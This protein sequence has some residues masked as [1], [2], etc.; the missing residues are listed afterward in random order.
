[1]LNPKYITLYI[2]CL[3]QSFIIYLYVILYQLYIV[4]TISRFGLLKSF[5]I[6]CNFSSRAFWLADHKIAN[7]KLKIMTF[8]YFA[9][10]SVLFEC[11]V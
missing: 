3:E 9:L 6:S 11:M 7:Y 2:K 1:M 10:G 8:V 5:N 4:F